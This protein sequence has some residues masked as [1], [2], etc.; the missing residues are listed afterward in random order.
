MRL[1]DDPGLAFGMIVGGSFL[2]AFLVAL[3]ALLRTFAHADRMDGISDQADDASLDLARLRSDL[4]ATRADLAA[5][6]AITAPR[7]TPRPPDS[8]S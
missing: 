2:V 1:L 6:S 3:W 7:A 8:T 5:L 4:R